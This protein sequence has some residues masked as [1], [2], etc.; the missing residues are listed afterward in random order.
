MAGASS[1]G[2]KAV[3]APEGEYSDPSGISGTY[4]CTPDMPYGDSKKVAHIIKMEY[5][6]ADAELLLHAKKGDSPTAFYME[7]WMKYAMENIGQYQFKNT[8]YNVF[9]VEPGVMVMGVTMRA[10]EDYPGYHN[11][12]II[13]DTNRMHPVLMIKDESKLA[14]YSNADVKRIFSEA[15]TLAEITN[16][17]RIGEKTAVP[18]VGSMSQDKELVAKAVEL[19]KAKWADSPDPDRFQFAYIYNDE[20]GPVSYGKLDGKGV[21]T[22]SD[23]VTAIMFFKNKDN[24][25]C[26]YYAIGISRESTDISAEELKKNRG[27]HMTGNSTIQYVSEKRMN[28]TRALSNQ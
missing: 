23:E 8:S 21:Y 18:K 1:G 25:V 3:E 28:E 16:V 6:E 14:Q 9:S 10:P 20:W 2:G 19:M 5:K 11:K 17:I 24:G 15:A 4:F 27:L 7:N 26:Y 12:L 13:A 22:F